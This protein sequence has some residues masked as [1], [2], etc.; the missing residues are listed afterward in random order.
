MDSEVEAGTRPSPRAVLHGEG[1]ETPTAEPLTVRKPKS[2]G[3]LAVEMLLLLPPGSAQAFSA[4]SVP[5]E[6]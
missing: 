5:K 1:L 6:L 3:R 2:Q 4:S